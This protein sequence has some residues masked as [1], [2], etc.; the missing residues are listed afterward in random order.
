MLEINGLTKKY[1]RGEQIVPA[2]CDLSMTV[3]V[4]PLASLP[5]AVKVSKRDA[6]TSMRETD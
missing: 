3:A 2:V 4:G 5:A 6:Y 1:K